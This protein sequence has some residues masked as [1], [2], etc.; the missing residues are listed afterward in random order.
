VSRPVLSLFAL[1]RGALAAFS[2]ELR[3][4]LARDDRAGLSSLLGLG[5][6]LT[7]R[8]TSAGRAVDLM[9]RPEEDPEV[10]PLFASLRRVAKRA[11]L[12]HV[13]TSEAPSLEGRLRAYDLLRDDEDIAKMLDR[14]LDVANLPWFL[15]RPGT[16]GGWLEDGPRAELA[17][18]MQALGPSL[19]DEVNAFVDA[20]G[21]MDGDVLVHDRL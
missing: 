5:D 14:L 16:T 2:A 8:L 17:E 9:L 20:L 15:Q 4:L 18:R 12:E 11:A 10:L 19:P 7:R 6:E 21:A 13:W 1:D 3:G